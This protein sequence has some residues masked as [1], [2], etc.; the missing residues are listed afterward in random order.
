M[1]YVVSLTA[2][3]IQLL[4]AG[5]SAQIDDA[6][7]LG[8]GIPAGHMI[9]EGDI[10]VPED[11]FTGRACYA[12][13]LWPGGVV[14]FE[15]DGNVSSANQTQ[16]FTA[17]SEWE[18][19][20]NIDFRH[21]HWNDAH[22]IHIRDAR[23][24]SSAVGWKFDWLY[25]MSWQ[26]VNISNWGNISD[27]DSHHVIVHELGHA[28]GLWHEQSRADRDAFVEIHWLRIRWGCGDS[29]DMWC[30]YNFGVREDQGPFGS[31][32]YGPYDFDSIMHYGQCDFSVC[33]RDCSA[34]P[35][36][37]CQNNLATC[38]TITV[39]PPNQSM[40]NVIGRQTHPSVLDQLTMSFMYP[41][42]DWRFLDGSTTRFGS[43]GFF[44]PFPFLQWGMLMTP[45]DGTLWVQPGNYTRMGMG[46]GLYTRPMTIRAPLGGVTIGG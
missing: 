40:Q 34:N 18:S 25:P 9:I 32:E 17:M 39:L 27:P 5:A 3:A 7:K 16:M 28:L 26:V 1:R 22:W 45:V 13:N 33:S 35:A 30:G 8:D 20:A 44:D 43:G 11:F 46:V 29:G 21:R 4:A 31:G 36:T 15:F 2:T 38:R 10:I 37:C 41:E 14:P 6:L 42:S 19:V 23:R 12:T 24:N